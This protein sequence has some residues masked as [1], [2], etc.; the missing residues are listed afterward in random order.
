MKKKAICFR[1]TPISFSG[2]ALEELSRY[3]PMFDAPRDP[4]EGLLGPRRRSCAPTREFPVGLWDWNKN[5]DRE[6][7]IL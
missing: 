6:Q 3:N 2:P 7:Y 1:G 4:I 5:L